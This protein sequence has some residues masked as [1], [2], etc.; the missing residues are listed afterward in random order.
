MESGLILPWEKLLSVYS[1]RSHSASMEFVG[2]PWK[3]TT[4]HFSTGP[5]TSFH[6]SSAAF[7]FMKATEASPSLDVR[8]ARYKK[9][10]A[11]G[12]SIYSNR[13]AP[14]LHLFFFLGL[15]FSCFQRTLVIF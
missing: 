12:A 13:L 8:T 4:Y 2:L 7:D 10:L 6:E 11:S 5:S 3:R 14:F 1:H 15:S 9:N